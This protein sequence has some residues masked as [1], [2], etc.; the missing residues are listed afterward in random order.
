MAIKNSETIEG[1][2]DIIITCA[3]EVLGKKRAVSETIIGQGE[4][5]GSKIKVRKA[6][7]FDRLIDLVPKGSVVIE[8]G[9]N[10]D[11]YGFNNQSDWSDVKF[12]KSPLG[13]V[14]IKL[15]DVKY[16]PF[17]GNRETVRNFWS[18][19]KEEVGELVQAVI[20]NRTDTDLLHALSVI[21]LPLFRLLKGDYRQE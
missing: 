6:S 4:Q 14:D 18:D 15:T 10:R 19:S 3:Q 9:N 2:I 5:Y 21:E 13:R 7:F 11:L 8:A 12:I 17:S 1:R 20:S 16:R